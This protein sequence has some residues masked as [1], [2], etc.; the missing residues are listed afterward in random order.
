MILP[1]LIVPVIFLQLAIG[2]DL[3][4]K[5]GHLIKSG[6]LKE[7]SSSDRI[8][9]QKAHLHSANILAYS[10]DRF[11]QSSRSGADEMRIQQ[12]RYSYSRNNA[13]STRHQQVHINPLLKQASTASIGILF[14]LLS[15]RSLAAYEL[16]DQFNVGMQRIVAVTPTVLILCANIAGFLVN[17][18]KPLNFKNILKFILALNIA[19]E[20]TELLY[21]AVMLVVNGRSSNAIVPTEVYFGRFF[22]NIW[23]LSLC[24]TFSKSRW[25]HQV[26]PPAAATG[27]SPP[28]SAFPDKDRY[29]DEDALNGVQG[30]F[31]QRR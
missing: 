8:R 5:N 14:V 15:W 18:T 21:N 2:S 26:T 19:R 25:V 29:T 12:Q 1:K 28:P 13:Q 17:M 20:F 11:E 10:S 4:R 24:I 30:Q 16:A 31:G 27:G 9:N 23:W 22:M 7:G 3:S 6:A